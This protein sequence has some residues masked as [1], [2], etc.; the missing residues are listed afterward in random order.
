[1]IESLASHLVVYIIIAVVF[2]VSRNMPLKACCAGWGLFGPE[3]TYCVA[4]LLVGF[5]SSSGS[6]QALPLRE[7]LS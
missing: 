6:L 4:L 3:P 1:M 2:A 5:E 7:S